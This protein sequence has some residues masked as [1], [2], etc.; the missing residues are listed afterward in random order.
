MRALRLR[1]FRSRRQILKRCRRRRHFF[2]W[3]DKPASE[4]T[5]ALPIGNGRL[6]AMIFGGPGDRTAPTK[7]RHA[8]CR[9]SLR[10]KQSG[11][12]ESPPRSPP[13][14]L[15]RQIQR[16]TRSG[17]REDDGPANQ[18]DAVRTGWRSETLIPRSRQ[19]HQLSPPTRSRHG[20]RHGLLQ[21]LAR[22]LSREKFLRVR[23]TRSSSSV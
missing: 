22:P 15:R 6:G 14:D 4:W 10:S 13:A 1:L 5:E 18:A 3:Y 11:S 2:L 20:Y 12:T 16:S 8:L 9:L 21:T 7:R 23:W 19:R 17:W